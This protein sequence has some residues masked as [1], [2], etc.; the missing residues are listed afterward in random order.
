M[1]R[2]P[3]SNRWFL[4]AALLLAG[5]AAWPLLSEAGLLNTRGGGD[6]PFLL[7]RLHQLSAALADGHFPVRWMPDANYGFG[8]PFFNFYAPLSIYIAALFRWLGFTLVGAIKA[9]QLAGFLVAAWGTFVLARRWFG[10]HWA[11]LLAATA[12]SLAPFHMVNVYVRGD[13]L[14]EFWA[15]AWYPLVLLAT[16]RLVWDDLRGR[17]RLHAIATLALVYAALVL[18]HNISALIF[19]PF[20]VLYLVIGVWIRIGT[21]DSVQRLSVAGRLLAPLLAAL[22]L[23][24][25]LSAWFWLPAL[26]ERSLAQ[27]DP[28]TS[29]YFHYSNHFRGFDLIQGR[30]WFDYDVADGRAFRSGLL[31]ALLAGGGLIL[32]LWPKRSQAAQLEPRHRGHRRAAAVFIVLTLAIATVM[33]TP[34]SRPLWANLPLLPFTQFPWRFLSVQALA[35]ALATGALALL[36]ARRIVAILCLALLLAAGL[37]DLEVDHLPLSDQDVTNQRLVDYEWFTGNIGTTVSA[38]YLPPYVQ[39]R[40]FT[41]G[42]LEGETRWRVQVLEGDLRRA[43]LSHHSTDR[44]EWQLDSEGDGAVLALPTLYWPG[45]Q[46]QLDENPMSIEPAVGSGAI[47]VAVPAGRHQ[48]TLELARTPIRRLAEILSLIGLLIGLGLWWRRPN[49][50]WLK[51]GAAVALLLLVLVLIGRVWPRGDYPAGT[52]TWDFAQLGYLHHAPEGIVFD[53]GSLLQRYDYS[54]AELAAGETLTID[55]AWQNLPDSSVSVG[56]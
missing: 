16:D 26:A 23:G 9:A 47:Q 44:Q 7:Q 17:R 5:A 54:G 39:P 10:T 35:A 14:A 36:P 45:W 30:L 50:S 43:S 49:R 37:L 42:W 56:L 32:L 51:A 3:N 6:S 22:A 29:G 18:S 21:G 28:V 41:S 27:L 19:S 55:L 20:V 34:I 8:Y 52:L 1:N 15:M 4:A 48:L 53:D 40:P 2:R 33:I 13:S 46:A 11:A 38:E 25:L 31:Q 24:L 12:Y